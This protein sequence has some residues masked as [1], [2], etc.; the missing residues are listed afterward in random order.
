MNIQMLGTGN[1]FGK[2]YYN[3]NALITTGQHKLMVDC[4]ITAPISLYQLGKT[5]NDIDGILISHIHADHVGGLEELAFQMVFVYKRKPKLYI[6]EE[7]VQPLWEHTLRGGLQQDTFRALDDFFEVVPLQEQ[8]PYQICEGLVVELLRTDHIPNK[9]S[10]SFYFNNR[11]FYSADMR[12]NPAL[13][14]QLVEERGCEH[15]L[16]D[17]QL[18]N[19][20]AVHTTLDELLS[21]PASLQEK[22][23]L[24]HYNDTKDE[25]VGQTGQ[26]RFI[27]Q[28][29]P[30]SL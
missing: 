19:P 5:F 26:M 17:C 22:I 25:F 8:T 29:I 10:F 12:F 11:I 13:L 14:Q 1:A 16:H 7:L 30:Y 15:I 9:T 24:M 3:N 18:I 4:G 21:L 28:H 2:K 27:E 20:G 6:S 23:W